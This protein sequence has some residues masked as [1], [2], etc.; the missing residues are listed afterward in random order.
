MQTVNPQPTLK[1]EHQL[2]REM[3]L[4]TPIEVKGFVEKVKKDETQMELTIT[5]KYEV[6]KA[7]IDANHPHFNWWRDQAPARFYGR[8]SLVLT[9]PYNP[10][11]GTM[12]GQLRDFV[13]E[14]Y[15]EPTIVKSKGL[16]AQL[17][18]HLESLKNPSLQALWRVFLNNKE[19]R[20]RFFF[21][22]STLEHAYS[23]KGGLA[24]HTVLMMDWIE[25]QIAASVPRY[26]EAYLPSPMDKDLLKTAAL[27]HDT[28]KMFALQLEEGKVTTTD[29]GHF[30]G[31]VALSLQ[32]LNQMYG[33]LIAE[34]PECQFNSFDFLHLQHIIASANGERE[35]G[36][37]V[38]PKTKE[39]RYF[40]YLESLET[41]I[42]NYHD[43]ERKHVEPGFTR[44]FNQDVY[45]AP[46][47]GDYSEVL[48][49][50]VIPQ[51]APTSQTPVVVET[52]S[53][54][55]DEAPAGY[56]LMDHEDIPVEEPIINDDSNPEAP[57][58]LAPIQ[59]VAPEFVETI[60]PITTEPT[61]TVSTEMTNPFVTPFVG[62]VSSESSSDAVHPTFMTP[63]MNIPAEW[64]Q[65]PSTA[66]VLSN[67]MPLQP[68]VSIQQPIDVSQ[69]S[70]FLPPVMPTVEAPIPFTP[71]EPHLE[72]E[73]TPSSEDVSISTPLTEEVPVEPVTEEVGDSTEEGEGTAEG[74]TPEEV[75]E[76]PKGKASTR[77]TTA[78]SSASSKSATKTTKTTKSTKSSKVETPVESLEDGEPTPKKTRGKTKKTT[79]PVEE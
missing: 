66:P 2:L 31:S 52:P 62:E 34:H 59:A 32:F 70:E 38:P 78:K 29:E 24:T 74:S 27:F 43:L 3:P 41:C 75:D 47:Q 72:M 55:L 22:P 68:V 46:Y 60:T 15:E 67:G 14:T 5:V 23:F 30:L 64:P 26:Y 10:K 21:A 48:P 54:S 69:P 37:I 39:A 17:K 13:Y 79:E 53:Q 76:K 28:G 11:F 36:A 61:P 49:E 58:L 35:Y 1:V 25:G 20:E 56:E 51:V 16:K 7:F 63:V 33:Q 12:I 73:P 65:T 6:V 8:L 4:G 18:A 19:L 57:S 77:K 71:S 45:V 44:L 40:A 42:G 9:K 50:P